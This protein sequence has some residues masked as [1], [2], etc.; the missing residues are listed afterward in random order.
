[1]GDR[2]GGAVVASCCRVGGRCGGAE[3]RGAEVRGAVVGV[4]VRCQGEMV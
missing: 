2:L 4:E 1:M 3:V